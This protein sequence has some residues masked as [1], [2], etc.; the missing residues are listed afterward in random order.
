MSVT[1][2]TYGIFRSH[3]LRVMYRAV[4]AGGWGLQ[5]SRLIGKLAIRFAVSTQ[6]ALAEAVVLCLALFC[7]GTRAPDV[8]PC[9][10]GIAVMQC[11]AET[12]HYSS[13]WLHCILSYMILCS[14]FSQPFEQ[15]GGWYLVFSRYKRCEHRYGSCWDVPG[16]RFLLCLLLPLS[17]HKMA[18]VV[19]C[20]PN[21]TWQCVSL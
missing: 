9:C 11:I 19:P 6:N 10:F 16:D 13:L 3:L 1:M 8:E 12:M 4:R 18:P 7:C 14:V 15:C 2:E 20:Y 5:T 21:R 17:E